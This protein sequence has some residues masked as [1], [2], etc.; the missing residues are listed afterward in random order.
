MKLQRI[1]ILTALVLVIGGIAYIGTTDIYIKQEQVTQT[2]PNDRFYK[3][4]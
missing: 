1:I 2:I 3:D 4:E